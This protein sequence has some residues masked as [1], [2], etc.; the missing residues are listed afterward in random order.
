MCIRDRIIE[1]NGESTQNVARADAVK[2]LKGVVGEPILL[3]IDRDG[4]LM[5]VELQRRAIPV[6]SVRGDYRD[7]DNNWVFRLEDYP[8]I[9]YIRLRNFGAQTADEL[10]SALKSIDGKVDGV[11]VDLRHNTGG[12]LTSAIRVCDLFLEGN[13][14]IVSTEGRIKNEKHT[15]SNVVGI[16]KD[17]RVTVLIN[18]YSASA[19]EIVA[20]CLQDHE[21]AVVIGEQSWGKGTVQDIIPVRPNR[22]VLKLTVAGYRRPSGQP[23]DRYDPAIETEG[24]WGVRP[25]SDNSL[26]LSD[27]D[28]VRNF[29]KRDMLDIRTLIPIEQRPKIME[30][31]TTTTTVPLP[32][33]AESPEISEPTEVEAT[34]LMQWEDRILRK[35][36]ELLKSE[37]ALGKAA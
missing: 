23:I 19:S 22:S 10:E 25:D 29:Q 28:L 7:E 15:S 21:R 20:G 16:A 8:R 36:I 13:K 17:V 6:S 30:L 3:T 12:L 37:P 31:L 2:K 27:L 18:R 4:E 24:V 11:I 5:P 32:E 26:V 14:T 35:A 34:D 9:G 33:D 1:I